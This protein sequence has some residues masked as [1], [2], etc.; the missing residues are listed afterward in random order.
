MARPKSEEEK[1]LT[2]AEIQVMN[3]L[4][5][6]GSGTVHEV[7]ENLV[8]GSSKDYAYTTV[9]TMLRVLEKKGV[10]ESHKEGRG[11]RYLPKI[12]KINYQNKATEHL[13]NNV[14]AGEKTAL[15]LNL[16]GSGNLSAKELVEVKE[17]LKKKA[18]DE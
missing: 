2:D 16:L 9:S 5:E 3:V 17:F 13:V 6:K 1:P 10:V 4:W 18:D 8:A 15:I 11:H 14:F 12:D 7:L